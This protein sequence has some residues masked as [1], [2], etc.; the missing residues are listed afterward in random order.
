MTNSGTGSN[1]TVDVVL[2]G[3]GIMSATL[4]VMLKELQP[5]LTIEIFERLDVIAAESSAPMNNAG[6]GH[7]AFCELNYTPQL[8]DGS[9]EIK[10]AI[11]I[12]EQFETSK[13]FWAYLIEQGLLNN[14]QSFIR[15]VPHMSF[16]WGEENVEYL[17]KRQQALTKHHFFKGM[18]YSE[19]KAQIKKWIP[20]VMEGRDPN[21][22]VSATFMDIGT[23]VNFGSLTSALIDELKQKGGVNISLNHDVRDIKRN[24][25]STWKITVKDKNTGNKRKL[26]AK[27][28]FVGAGGGALPLLQ[29]S[30]IPESKGFGG[31][32][33]SGQWLVCNNPDVVKQHEAKVYGKASVGSPPMSVPHLDTRMIDGKR[34]LLF[35]PYA[36]FS[37]RFLKKGSLL[38]LFG[39]IKLNNILPLLAVGRDNWPLTKYLIS[40]V[41]Q[42][43]ADRLNAL[44]DYMPTA[45]AEE[46]DLDIAGQRVQVIKKD[47]KHTGVLEFGTEVVTSADGSISALLGASPG[48]STSVPI[49]IQLIERCFK[50]HVKTDAWQQKF[51]QMIPSYGES[52]ANNETL[53]D[54]TRARTSKVLGLV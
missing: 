11:K 49:M 33:V 27:F 16:V 28:V 40:Q 34:A 51:K 30:G 45:K 3:A 10:K 12:A 21:E 36:G 1:L 37:T 39:S 44:K 7:S 20:L 9:I 43:P 24:A 48:A 42:S 54:E 5:D 23:D 46:W 50:N 53:S 17:K 52:L 22:K 6:T 47:A 41:L 18:E 26:N 38:D 31:F 2:I 29:K 4:G 8:P 32:P 35:G 25:D 15:K 14:P 19:E 13:E